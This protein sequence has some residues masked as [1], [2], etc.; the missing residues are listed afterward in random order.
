MSNVYTDAVSVSYFA[1]VHKRTLEWAV[2]HTHIDQE[3][4]SGWVE[5]K[6]LYTIISV[7]SA[8]CKLVD[9]IV[10]VTLS[11]PLNLQYVLSA[12]L[13]FSPAGVSIFDN[14]V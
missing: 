12:L 3:S 10:S 2:N 9:T 1:V 13:F 6:L 8:E 14:N 7:F 11:T 5:C 4:E